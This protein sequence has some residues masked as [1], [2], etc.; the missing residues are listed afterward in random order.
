V[1]A[2][3]AHILSSP[4]APAVSGLGGMFDEDFDLVQAHHCALLCIESGSHDLRLAVRASAR[5]ASSSG[6]AAHLL[7]FSG[8]RGGTLRRRPHRQAPQQLT[9][10]LVDRLVRSGLH[11]GVVVGGEVGAVVPMVA[12]GMN[13][14]AVV[15]RC[16]GRSRRRRRSSPPPA[17][18]Q[19]FVRCR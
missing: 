11:P 10:P 8:H 5:R 16:R 14:F 1:K 9:T 7:Y 12:G 13:S 4:A 15:A 6:D 17:H 19:R 18:G 3:A 2:P